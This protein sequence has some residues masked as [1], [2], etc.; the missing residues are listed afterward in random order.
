MN[1]SRKGHKPRTTIVKDKN[2]DVLADSNNILK[3]WKNYF[4]Q[5]LNV[6]G[7]N[8]VKQT[9]LHIAKTLHSEIQKF[10]NSVVEG[11]YYCKCLYEGR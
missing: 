1:G 3:R 2:G 11:I 5:L 7:I 9:K 4:G 6:H 8:N 10:I